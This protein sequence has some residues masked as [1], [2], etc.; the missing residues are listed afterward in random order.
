LAFAKDVENRISERRIASNDI[1]E[2]KENRSWILWCY[3]LW[4][5]ACFVKSL[6]P[7]V[8]I[9]QDEQMRNENIYYFVGIE[10]DFKEDEV[11]V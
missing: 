6:N 3:K 10:Y 11:E 8:I 2:Y 9:Y 4:L 5:R 1:I 7:K